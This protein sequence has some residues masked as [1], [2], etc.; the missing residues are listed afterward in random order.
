M[1]L[2]FKSNL[3]LN[4]KDNLNIDNIFLS[5]NNPRYTLLN[6]LEENLF[7]F[8]KN[9]QSYDFKMQEHTFLELLRSEGNFDDLK[10]LLDSIN[11]R[12][13]KNQRENIFLI[14]DDKKFIVAEGNRRI[15][16]LKLLTERFTLPDYND[17]IWGKN[18][19]SNENIDADDYNVEIE[20]KD[21]S[22][23]KDCI[24][25]IKQIKEKYKNSTFEI[26]YRIIES[27]SEL[28]DEIYNKHLN[29]EKTGLRKWSRSKYFAD[30][31]NLFPHGINKEKFEIIFNTIKRDENQILTD[32]KEAQFVKLCF[33][34]GNEFINFDNEETDIEK[35][36]LD[37]MKISKNISGLQSNHSFRK[38]KEILCDE[39][40]YI[41]P[42]K[43]D[44]EYFSFDFSSGDNQINLKPKKL[45]SEKLFDFIYKN[46]K[47][48]IITTRPI[49]N[50][51]RNK[52]FND[53]ILLI[54]G[55]NGLDYSKSEEEL[56]KIDE[57][58]LSSESL[59]LLI[60]NNESKYSNRPE[61]LK[62]FENALKIFNN[63]NKFIKSINE[64]LNEI[65]VEPKNV[66]EIL[67]NQYKFI[68]N[69]NKLF[70]NALSSTIRSFIEQL[71]SWMYCYTYYSDDNS[72]IQTISG[73]IEQRKII[74]FIS[75]PF[76]KNLNSTKIRNIID[77]CYSS[78][79]NEN[80][81]AK[82]EHMAK[83]EDL[84]LPLRSENENNNE[85]S[86][87]NALVY[88]N[89]FIHNSSIAYIDAN[90]NE[91]IKLI[92]EIQEFLIDAWE[93]LKPQVFEQINKL[94]LKEIQEKNKIKI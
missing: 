85:I 62:R 54:N 17:K 79:N 42:E 31:L 65:N 52:F 84:L 26:Y 8:F 67:Y 80:S 11:K 35:N 32:Y 41:S 92:I 72:L 25:F 40:L 5:S 75:K 30:L 78:D 7:D 82:K 66:F 70:I 33:K 20:K 2:I 77:K 45:S 90:Y 91:K 71:F 3:N 89:S 69:N 53:L 63:N 16:I 57:F 19:Y 58:S 18:H 49:K 87:K 4:L 10:K 12:G 50:E 68:I 37:K 56:E 64:K 44:N 47:N 15:M 74:M 34:Y 81:N 22:N 1:K 43:F 36:I 55:I 28:W 6:N 39:I 46:W 29:G 83:W 88:L 93:L 76:R 38:I 27:S 86:F 73:T 14:K 59:E 61:Y 51:Y 60:K 23:Y 24:E 9:N 94:I 21:R 48:G 13:F